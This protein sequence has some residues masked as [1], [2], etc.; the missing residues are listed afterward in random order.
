MPEVQTTAPAP[1]LQATVPIADDGAARV[2]LRKSETPETGLPKLRALCKAHRIWQ[3]PLLKACTGGQLL[4][5]D[6][7]YVF[8]Q[9]YQ[10]S[11]HFTRYLSALMTRCE[12]DFFRSKLSENLWEEGG[13]LEPEKR[14]AE[15]FRNFLRDGL[16]LAVEAIKPE[17]F[18]ELFAKEYLDFCVQSSPCAGSAFLSLGTEAVV[19]DLYAIF[20]TGLRR[21]EI[22]EQHLTFFKIHIECDDEHAATLEEMMASYSDEP[23][24]YNTCRRAMTHAL[25]LRDQ[26]FSAVYEAIQ[27]RRVQ[28]LMDNIQA[29]QSLCPALPDPTSLLHPAGKTS[30]RLYENHRDELNIDFTVERVPFEPEVFDVR[31][32]RIPPGKVNE[33][34]RHAHESIFCILA[35]Q[36]RVLVNDAVVPVTV[37]DTVF[38]PRWCFHQTQNSGSEELVILAV[39]DYGL[40]KRAFIGDYLKTARLK[41]GAHEATAVR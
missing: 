33:K 10:Y 30:P 8:A 5:E 25:D 32:V 28:S 3:N 37:G 13:A 21:A 18:A 24:W 16:G 27:R 26:F 41:Q 17:P 34:H 14:H 31:T 4:F 11:R 39:T 12:N 23:D 9:Y 19:A 7:R 22:P 35:G 36:G 6:F 15:I 20:L 29:R 2:R 38:V 40:T 1:E